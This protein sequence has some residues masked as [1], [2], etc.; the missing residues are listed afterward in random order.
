LELA[1]VLSVFQ[2]VERLAE[3]FSDFECF[4]A[5]LQLLQDGI[6]RID[7]PMRG[8]FQGSKDSLRVFIDGSA[9]R[10]S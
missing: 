9:G 4:W 5:F 1:S 3:N 6:V 2:R 7:A 10:D 8:L